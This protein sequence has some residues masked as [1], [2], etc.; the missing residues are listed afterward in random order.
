MSQESL[1]KEYLEGRYEAAINEIKQ[2]TNGEEGDRTYLHEEMLTPK[3]SVSGNWESI[4]S[5]NTF[6]SA[7]FVTTDSEIPVKR[8]D[9]LGKVTGKLVKSGMALK[10]NE[11]QMQ[12]IDTMRA[13]GADELDILEEILADSK[14]CI[15]GEKELMERAFLEEL[16]SGVCVIDDTENVGIGVRI[17]AGYLDENKFHP[18]I[19]WSDTENSK[20][21]DD[22]EKIIEAANDKK[23]E[24]NFCFMDGATWK[25]FRDSK[26]VREYVAG[27]GDSKIIVAGGS[28]AALPKYSLDAVNT[29]LKEDQDYGFEIRVIKYKAVIEKNGQRTPTVPWQQGMIVFTKSLNVGKLWWA[30]VAEDNHRVS[31]VTYQDLGNGTLLSKYSTNQPTLTEWTQIQARTVP[32]INGAENIYQLDITTTVTDS[33]EDNKITI[34]GTE[35]KKSD[36]LTAITAVTGI[37]LPAGTSDAAVVQLFNSWNKKIQDA[38]VDAIVDTE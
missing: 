23:R 11:T 7:D 10:L 37:T 19:P 24:L 25:L 30:K 8:R 35:H 9:S 27:K 1:Y 5:D 18:Q 26:Q 13:V 28:T 15:R 2:T 3:L 4:S 38:V 16:S 6:V 14:R 17:D 36:V 22:F 32:V 31:G 21:L 29:A 12:D 33:S 20:P 34:A